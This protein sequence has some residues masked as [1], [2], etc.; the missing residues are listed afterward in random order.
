ML[1]TGYNACSQL[2]SIYNSISQIVIPVPMS[3]MA[4][5]KGKSMGTL[6]KHAEIYAAEPVRMRSIPRESF[7]QDERAQRDG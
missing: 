2:S 5:H 6:K 3:V 1:C 7:E 4:L